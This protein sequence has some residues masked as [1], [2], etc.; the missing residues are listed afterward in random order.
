MWNDFDKN[1]EFYLE[2]LK[3]LTHSA[4][5]VKNIASLVL[6]NRN[7]N[8]SISLKRRMN[9]LKI[10]QSFVPS[11]KGNQSMLDVGFFSRF[12]AEIETLSALMNSEDKERVE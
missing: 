1:S 3:I 5:Q 2:I 8:F 9:K 7:A 10:N 6:N 11:D 12:S 4:M